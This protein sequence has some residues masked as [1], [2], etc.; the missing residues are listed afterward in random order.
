MAASLLLSLRVQGWPSQLR[1]FLGV[2][3][4]KVTFP[5]SSVKFSGNF[6]GQGT[7]FIVPR[8][9]RVCRPPLWRT[10]SSR[11]EEENRQ[12]LNPDTYLHRGDHGDL[13]LCS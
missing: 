1:R 2:D 8:A 7:S 6:R 13:V 12:L 9:G 4:D 11:P 10:D 3:W 5:S